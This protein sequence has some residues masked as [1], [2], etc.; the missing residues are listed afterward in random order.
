[1]S[2]IVLIGG[3]IGCGKS[4][5]VN[6]FSKNKSEIFNRSFLNNNES[7]NINKPE[8]EL[9]PNEIY[10]IVFDEICSIEEQAE[11]M[12]TLKGW[13]NFR[14]DLLMAAEHFINNACGSECQVAGPLSERSQNLLDKIEKL[15]DAITPESN[16]IF[17]VEDNFYYRSMRYDWFQIARRTNI[18]FCEVFLQCPLNTAIHRNSIRGYNIPEQKIKLMITCMEY[19]NP[20]KYKW[21]KFSMIFDS[22]AELKNSALIPILSLIEEARNNPAELMVNEEKIEAQKVCSKN[23]VHQADNI[24]RKLTSK[25]ISDFKENISSKEDFKSLVSL[26]SDVRQELLNGIR[27]GEVHLPTSILENLKILGI[28]KVQKEYENI[29]SEI[30]ERE[31][32]EKIIDVNAL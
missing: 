20:T 11:L 22:S 8:V 3:L 5:L 27:N 30:F 13:R 9:K 26:V 12:K 7:N 1:M 29:L 16:G 24:L 32:Q 15:N 2:C 17:F 14:V 6:F 23:A 19:P 28:E 31:L 18:G 25:K 21:E 4:T 10:K